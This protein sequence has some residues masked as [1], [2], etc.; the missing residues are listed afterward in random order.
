MPFGPLDPR[1]GMGKK[2]EIRIQSEHP[3]SYFRELGTIFG[4]KILQ[5]FGFKILQFFYASGTRNLFDPGSGIQPGSKKCG[6]R[7]G[8][9][10]SDPQ[11]WFFSRCGYRSSTPPTFLFDKVKF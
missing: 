2:I 7:S 4:F 9:N 11:H 5:F 3:G 8:I 1:S 10:I 6:S